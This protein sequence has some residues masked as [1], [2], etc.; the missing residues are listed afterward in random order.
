MNRTTEGLKAACETLAAALGL[1]APT[2]YK[3]R[4][5]H[6]AIA[7]DKTSGAGAGSDGGAWSALADVLMSSAGSR[8]RAQCNT[9]F[10]QRDNLTRAEGNERH[11]RE[12]VERLRTM[13]ADAE[14]ALAVRIEEANA[15]RVTLAGLD[16][17]LDAPARAAAEALAAVEG[18]R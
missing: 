13:L 16:A 2:C 5:W 7:G 11:A 8:V 17:M 3:R 4:G 14:A 15:A 12:N 9:Y 10:G 6:Y 1:P 18:A